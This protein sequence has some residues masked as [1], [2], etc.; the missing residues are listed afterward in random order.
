V[1]P[2]YLPQV[3]RSGTGQP[4]PWW[5]KAGF[6]IRPNGRRVAVTV[7]PQSRAIASITWGGGMPAS[8]LLFEGCVAGRLWSAYAGGFLLAHR[9]ACVMLRIAEGGRSQV[10]RFGLG[11][12]C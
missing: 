5:H 12:R 1:P 4:R 7:M 9:R 11:R 6:L 8:K 3:V 10:V 2:V